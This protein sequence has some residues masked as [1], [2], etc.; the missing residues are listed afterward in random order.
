MNSEPIIHVWITKYALSSGITE[1][2]MSHCVNISD[3]MVADRRPG[4]WHAT[5]HKPD[6]HT[7]KEE[8]IARAE[9]MRTN[10]IA[11]LK[12]SIKKLEGLKFE[13]VK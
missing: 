1:A 10:K 2:D 12:K 6:W 4:Q 11:S 7:T 3:K 5:Y 13:V 9:V 8:A